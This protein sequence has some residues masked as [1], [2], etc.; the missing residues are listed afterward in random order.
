M[1]NANPPADVVYFHDSP[2]LGGA[3]NSLLNLSTNLDRERFT[4]HFIIHGEGGFADRIRD[5]GMTVD[6]CEFPPLKRPNPWRMWRAVRSMKRLARER[7]A[8]I[9]HGNTPRAN[10]YAACV[11]K[12]IGARVVWHARNL[13]VPGMKDIDNWLSF[14]PD[15]ILCNSDAIRERFKGKPKAITIINGVNFDVFDRALPGEPVRDE[16]GIPHDALVM[17]ITS[18]LEREKGH[19]CL[20]RAAGIV[21]KQAPNAWFLIVGKAFVDVDAREAELRRL[22]EEMGVAG[23]TVFAGFRTDIPNVLA[24]MDVLVLAAD[25]EPCGRVLFEAEAMAL[26][27]VGTNTGGTPEIVDDGVTGILFDPGDH[28]ALAKHLIELCQ[29]EGKRRQMGEAG[30]ERARAM[31]SIQAHVAKTERVYSELLGL[32]NPSTGE[33]T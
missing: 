31:F 9:V 5:A 25:A 32:D 14:L 1:A 18:R 8:R 33:D 22:A 19:D 15:R 20:L 28:E 16:L 26:P 23:Q 10:F 27:I 2:V 4:P 11:G 21:V 17:G 24:A 30:Y 6:F 7:H 3:E 29:N 13:L 12:Q